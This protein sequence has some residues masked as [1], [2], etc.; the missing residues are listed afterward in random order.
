MR[1]RL[2]ATPL[3]KSRKAV[4]IASMQSAIGS[5]RFTSSSVMMMVTRWFVPCRAWDRRV[6]LLRQFAARSS[7]R[8]NVRA[9][10]ALVP[11]ETNFVSVL[12]GHSRPCQGLP[13]GFVLVANDPN[14]TSIDSPRSTRQGKSDDGFWGGTP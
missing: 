14:E 12:G 6:A 5:S 10:L 2:T 9:E 11:F 3:A 1:G 13:H 8:R 4:R 7:T